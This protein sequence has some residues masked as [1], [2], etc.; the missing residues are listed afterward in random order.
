MER[1]SRDQT[2][3]GMKRR[4]DV[5]EVAE[6]NGWDCFW[7]SELYRFTSKIHSQNLLPKFA[8]K[9]Y[10]QDLLQGIG[11]PSSDGVT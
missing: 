11:T 4:P 7:G 8:S 2:A 6:E 9:V 10:S 5:S 3:C 1:R